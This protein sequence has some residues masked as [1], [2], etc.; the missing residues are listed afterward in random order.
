MVQTLESCSEGC[1]QVS[2]WKSRRSETA[3]IIRIRIEA[4]LGVLAKPQSIVLFCVMC[5]FSY[6][7]L[8]DPTGY[9]STHLRPCINHIKFWISVCF[10]ISQKE[11][12]Y[13]ISVD[14]NP[15]DIIRSIQHFVFQNPEFVN[16]KSG[17]FRLEADRFVSV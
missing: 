3:E 2:S 10:A 6:R 7:N 5:G 15:R 1:C 11:F 9:T 17:W 14:R 12:V 4:Y 16:A 8:S 13:L